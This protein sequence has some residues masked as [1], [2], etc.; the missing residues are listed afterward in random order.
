WSGVSRCELALPEG[1][2]RAIFLKRQENHGTFS[3]RHPVGGV[4]TFM[5]E[6]RRI[7]HYRACG[8]P[9]L[10]PVYFA[11]RHGGKGHRAILATEELT[12]FV[13]MEDRVQ[14]WLREGAPARPIRL[15]YMKAVAA[16]LRK[17][18]D[19]GI[20]HNCFFPKHVFVRMRPDGEVEARVIDLEKSRWRPHGAIC[21]RRDLYSLNHHSLCWSR[22]D[23]MWFFK[24]YLQIDRLTPFAKWLWHHIAARS[25]RKNRARAPAVFLVAKA[26]VTD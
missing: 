1:G 12:G 6:F 23:R 17:M 22:S 13:S 8:I 18:H 16:L 4:P 10:E 15:R 5:R 21:A 11:M 9:T 3:L 25:T 26:G 24:A 7:Q 14:R 2:S 20:Q 19:R